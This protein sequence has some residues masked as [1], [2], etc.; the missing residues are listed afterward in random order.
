MLQLGGRRVLVMDGYPSVQVNQAHIDK[1]G[2]SGH[3]EDETDA[4]T[5]HLIR[6]RYKIKRCAWRSDQLTRYLRALDRLHI[7]NRFSAIAPRSPGNWPRER[8]P[9]SK[10]G[11]SGAVAGLPRNFYDAKWLSG[12]SKEEVRRLKIQEIAVDLSIPD[13]VHE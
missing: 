12:L 4:E 5:K 6:P 10:I 13:D 11:T 7:Y 2:T 8:I 3:S 9:G 1:L